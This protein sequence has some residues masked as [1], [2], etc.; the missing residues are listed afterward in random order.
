MTNSTH[1]NSVTAAIRD[2]A[3]S[4]GFD[5]VG[6]AKAKLHTST[7]N[8]LFDFVSKGFHGDMGWLSER[9]EKRSD[10]RKLWPDA[11]TIIV[12]GLNYGPSENP[13]KWLSHSKRGAISVYAQGADYHNVLKKKLRLLAKYVAENFQS[14]VKL[15]VDTAPVMEKPLAQ[16]A[17]IGWQ[18]KHTNLVSKVS[19]SWLFIGEIFT[20]L[21]L[22]V[23][24]QE[25][26]HCGTCNR[27]ITVCPTKAFPAPYQLD[28]RRCISYLTI[29]HKGHIPREFRPLIGNRIFGCDDCLAVCPWNKFATKTTDPNLLAQNELQWPFL[30]N[31]VQLNESEFRKFFSGTTIKRLGRNR[32]IRNVLIAMGNS[33]KREFIPL[34][35][36][37]L[38][39]KSPLVRAMAIWALAQLLEPKIFNEV[40]ENKFAAEQDLT[41]KEE[42]SFSNQTFYS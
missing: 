31:L 9:R 30:G 7:R 24:E 14:E 16:K 17:G 18:G 10:P 5:A 15:F 11:K 40:R 21:D 26:D 32:F 12:I 36:E 13:L 38:E 23:G 20:T 39:D 27:C 19:G 3:L 34:V 28:S 8:H 33:K 42:W 2:R 29:E 25:I 41:V 1:T 22:S 37:Q 6:F 4:I 35:K